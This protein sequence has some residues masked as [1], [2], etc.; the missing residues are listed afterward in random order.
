MR[1]GCQQACCSGAA[2]KAGLREGKMAARPRDV[3]GPAS[4]AG[5]HARTSPRHRSRQAGRALEAAV[6]QGSHLLRCFCFSPRTAPKKPHNGTLEL[7]KTTQNVVHF[8]NG[9]CVGP[10]WLGCR[11]LRWSVKNV[12]MA[13]AAANSASARLSGLKYLVRHQQAL[14][15]DLQHRLDRMANTPSTYD[16]SR[17]R[18]TLQQ[19][20]AGFGGA[21]G[22]SSAEAHLQSALSELVACALALNEAAPPPRATLTSSML[23]RLRT[24]CLG[25]SRGR[26]EC[27]HF[28]RAVRLARGGSERGAARPRTSLHALPRKARRQAQRGGGSGA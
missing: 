24:T 25:A 17:N 15:D 2:A 14:A 26:A 12:I 21:E 20:T 10:R 23:Q 8:C 19:S 4:H 11:R 27:L 28:A 22:L 6:G 1:S 7:E 16:A 9:Q 5:V 13:A 3:L 18:P